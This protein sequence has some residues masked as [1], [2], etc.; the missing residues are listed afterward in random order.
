LAS[1]NPV[2]FFGFTYIHLTAISSLNA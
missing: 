2:A 1:L